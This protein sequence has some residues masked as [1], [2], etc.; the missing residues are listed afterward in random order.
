MPSIPLPSG[1]ALPV[2]RRSARVPLCRRL[3]LFSLLFLAVVALRPPPVVGAQHFPPDE[4]LQVMLDYLV[5]DGATP[6][7]V[8]GIIEADGSARVF[9]AGSGG[10][11]TPPLGPRSVFE[12]GSINKTFT[13]VLLA[14]MVIRGE[15]ALDDPVSKHLPEGVS[16]PARGGRAITLSD[17]ATHRSGLP[18][19]PDN[20]VPTDMADPYAGF[21]VEILYDFLTGHDLR[22]DPG[23]EGEYSNLGF[24]LLGHLLARAAGMSYRELLRERVLEPLGMATTMYPLEGEVADWMTK[25]HS[26]QGEVV[27]YWF[28]SEAIEGAGGLRSNLDDMLRYLKAHLDPDHAELG[29]A[30]R[31]ATEQREAMSET[32]GIGLGWQTASPQGR[33]IVTH[34]GGTG[35]FSTRIAY[36]RDRGVG[37]VLLTNTTQFPDDLGLDLLRFGPYVDRPEATVAA[38]T[39]DRYVGRYRISPGNSLFVR[40]EGGGVLTLQTPGNVRFRMYA[41]SDSSFFLKRAPWRVVFTRDRSGEVSGL[42][43]IVN[44]ATRSHPRISD[45]APPLGA[46]P[47]AEVLDLLLSAEDLA[48]YEGTYLL[49]IGPR[50]LELRLFGE[51]GQLLSQAAGQTVSRLRWQGDHVFAPEFDDTVRLVFTVEDDRAQRV[52]LYQGGGVFTGERRR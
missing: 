11:D 50:T 35:G 24:G 21:T 44:G 10:P 41:E 37:F 7:L 19:L 2:A 30:I 22:R 48:R 28:T 52:T 46:S 39:V 25:G 29:P 23:A 47:A 17:L 27:P 32:S 12:I 18:R 4:D 49:E 40:S 36:D 16:A 45:Q 51:D 13:G 6:G 20:Y 31:L 8:L 42:D 1:I 9:T 3:V 34:G 26:A 15:V 38:R 43:L 14:D 33:R 5:E